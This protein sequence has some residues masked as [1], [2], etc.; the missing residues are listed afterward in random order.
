M[1]SFRQNLILIG[2]PATYPFPGIALPARCPIPTIFLFSF[3]LLT[4]FQ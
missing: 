1:Y 2:L 4:H 3:V